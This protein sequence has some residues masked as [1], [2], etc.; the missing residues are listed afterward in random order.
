MKIVRAVFHRTLL[1]FLVIIALSYLLPN[2]VSA[3]YM[4]SD[5]EEYLESKT[6]PRRL[7]LQEVEQEVGI[8]TEGVR[9]TEPNQGQV[10]VI[11][12]NQVKVQR[13]LL[14]NKG[15]KFEVE[16]VDEE[17][18]ILETDKEAIEKDV[19]EYLDPEDE[20]SVKLRAHE[21]ANYVI[22]NR[23]AAKTNFPLTV[24]LETNELM[25]TTSKGTKIVTVLPDKAVA[26]MLAAKVLDQL[27]GKGGLRWLE[28][29]ASLETPL[30]S[31]DVKPEPAE[32]PLPT[33]T[34]SPEPTTTP[35][36]SPLPS[37]GVSPTTGTE[38]TEVS[39]DLVT[40]DDGELVYEFEGDK[41]EKLL[42]VF[43]V[44]LHRVVVM[45]AETGE[46]LEIKQNFP[47]KLLDYLSN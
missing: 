6:E 22:R 4:P 25:V 33:E 12:K 10:S 20:D 28:Y 36:A 47:V 13:V 24:N 44:K 15:E 14:R 8:E 18:N 39:A 7:M 45:S 37:D 2:G 26:N 31:P 32:S 1:F 35:E 11:K 34:A 46:L 23:V 17:G 42:G 38:K 29:Q 41:Y 21:R 30:P 9:K 19:V 16:F 27:G 40:A 5:A 3:L 43:T